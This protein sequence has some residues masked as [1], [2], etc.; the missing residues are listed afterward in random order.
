[1]SSCGS[2]PLG[3]RLLKVLDFLRSF[4]FEPLL[5]KPLHVVTM[6]VSF[7]LALATAKRVGE[8]QTFSS[9]VAFRGP[10]LVLPRV[11]G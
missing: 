1:M 3:F 8:L 5:S 4:I 9:R 7:L 2:C 10:D 6:K 11:R